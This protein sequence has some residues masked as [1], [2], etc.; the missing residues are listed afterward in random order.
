[1]SHRLIELVPKLAGVRVALV[2]DLMLDRYIFGRTERVSPEAPIPILKF[3]R[4][5][6]R[7]GGAGF[8]AAAMATLGGR[9]WVSG[10]IGQDNAGQTVRQR[11][12]S[13]KVDCAG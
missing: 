2:G 11:L 10:T 1:M 8:V 3:S 5:E 7:L 6:H 12:N 4:E 9:V 13:I